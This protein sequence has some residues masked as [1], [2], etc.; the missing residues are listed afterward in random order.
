MVSSLPSKKR[1]RSLLLGDELDK[2]VQS[3]VRATHDGKGAVTTT[4]VLAAGEAIVQHHNKSLS[5]E[6]VGPINLI[7][8]IMFL[9]C[10]SFPLMLESKFLYT[11]DVLLSLFL[12][13]H[14]SLPS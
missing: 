8:K 7:M 3:Y 2:Q 1:G 10:R 12:P 13:Q 11:H 14:A 6:N 9:V 5:N 4:V